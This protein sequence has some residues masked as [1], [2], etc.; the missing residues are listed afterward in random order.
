MVMSDT[1]PA[2]NGAPSTA[3]TPTTPDAGSAE[4]AI[5][6]FSSETAFTGAV[7]IARALS[8][9][10]MVPQAYQNNIANCLVAIELASRIGCSVFA[11]MQNLAIIQGKPS[12]SSTF[13]IATVNSCGRFT[14]LR[15]RWE[16]K[17]GAK[18]Y[19]CRAVAKDKSDGEEC[20]GTLIT[21]DMA[22]AEGWSTKSGSKWLTMPE[23]MLQYR[24][25]AFWTRVYAPELS[26]G[27][28]TREEITD[29]SGLDTIDI[30]PMTAMPGSPKDLEAALLQEKPATKAEE[31]QRASDESGRQP[32][33]E[34]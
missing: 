16:G 23:Q 18:D 32:G 1:I 17:P 5:N 28:Q 21:L 27:M 2:A 7:R 10:T 31:P 33:E 6:A 11:A 13:L 25:A 9:S 19:G 8:Q 26:L 20:V 34:G 22:R 24:A 15:F 14:P 3:L 4:R 12:W 30:V 29:V